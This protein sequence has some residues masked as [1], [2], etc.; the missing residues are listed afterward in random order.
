M[1]YLAIAFYSL[2][3][4][5]QLSAATVSISLIKQAKRYRTCWL[6]LGIALSLMLG[7]CISPILFIIKSGHFNLLDAA[8]SVPISGFL[9]LGI[10]GIKK[11]LSDTNA[12]NEKLIQIKQFD[13]L[14]AVLSRQETFERAQLEIARSIRTKR[15]IALLSLDIDHFK[16]INDH[17]GHHVGDDVLKGMAGFIKTKIRAVDFIGRIGGEE[18]LIVLPETNEIKAMEVAERLRNSLSH[19]VCCV[20]LNHRIK[21]TVSIGVALIALDKKNDNYAD[22]LQTY[23]DQA[24]EAM[25]VAKKNGR[26]QCHLFK[27][28]PF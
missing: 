4:I 11:L 3:F 25:Y 18:F 15:P 8:L 12:L 1:L 27:T 22:I 24:D 26:N 16:N 10:F 9:F 2:S 20:H 21:I 14:T 19:F 17:W 7:R 5:A 28:H 6:F 13:F 23:V